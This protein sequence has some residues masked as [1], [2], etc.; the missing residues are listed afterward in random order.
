MAKPYKQQ[1]KES[2]GLLAFNHLINNV[3]KLLTKWLN[4]GMIE[5]NLT[6]GYIMTDADTKSQETNMPETVYQKT[7]GRELLNNDY[8]KNT[9]QPNVW[10]LSERIKFSPDK[11]HI[12]LDKRRMFLL[13]N[14][15]FGVMRQNMIE[16]CGESLTKAVLMRTGYT[17]GS[18]DAEMAARVRNKDDL[19]DAFSVGPQMHA[20]LGITLAKCKEFDVD[21]SK[22]KF[23]A[24]YIWY[25]S[26]EDD[27]HLRFFDIGPDP[28]CWFQIG[29]ASGYSSVFIGRQIIFKEVECRAQGYKNCLIVGKKAELWDDVIEEMTILQPQLS[30]LADN[31]PNTDKT[32]TP[33]IK[34]HMKKA[35]NKSKSKKAV[36]PLKDS[37]LQSITD[38]NFVGISPGFQFAFSKIRKVAKTDATVL[39]LGASGV[40]KEVFAKKLHKLSNRAAKPFIAVNC[41]AIPEAL[42]EAELFGVEKGAYTGAISSR[43]GRFER[44][45]GGILF[46]D[47]IGAISL[48]VQGKLLRAL[49]EKEIERVGDTKTRKI[50]TRVVAATNVNLLEEVAAGRF[51]EDL[52]F[53][54]NVFPIYI[55]PLHERKADIPL[56]IDHFFKKFSKRHK[57]NPSGFSER[58]IHTLF[59]YDWPGN[60]REMENMIERAIILADP[61]CP[62]DIPHLFTSGEKISSYLMGVRQDGQLDTVPSPHTL[63]D[64]KKHTQT[65]TPPDTQP[66][67][68]ETQ[69]PSPDIDDTVKAILNTDIAFAD[70]ENLLLAQAVAQTDGNLAKAARLLGLTRPQLA[71]RLKKS[72]QVKA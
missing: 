18:L 57:R 45:D 23:Y 26:I 2:K 43:K 31:L 54:L 44:A 22:G 56:L 13:H 40:G 39:F 48:A 52:Y 11:G 62:I 12:W 20:L 53:R 19:F 72:K 17:A 15:A 30:Q 38:E 5:G 34:R 7:S 42:I 32:Q 67:N 29:Y 35:T 50:S 51:R 65:D 10:D 21:V 33:P 58:A 37:R 25:D 61:G 9:A 64:S 46:L 4:R 14:R 47:E 70:I 8:Q 1:N 36:M 27:A 6:I 63:T 66:T 16:Q 28:V 3:T 49:Q 71:Y 69:N 55:P 59:T 60:I 41:A 68:G 24:E